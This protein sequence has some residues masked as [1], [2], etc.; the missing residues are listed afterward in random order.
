MITKE[1]RHVTLSHNFAYQ[2]LKIKYFSKES[3]F[4]PV[5]GRRLQAQVLK[6][7]ERA[8]MEVEITGTPEPIVNWFKDNVPITSALK[9]T[10]FQKKSFGERHQLTIHEGNIFFE[11]RCNIWKIIY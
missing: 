4:P 2:L 10:D 6:K 1:I 8:I 3:T 7:G 9:A 11:I 5:F